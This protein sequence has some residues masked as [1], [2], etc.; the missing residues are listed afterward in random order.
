MTARLAPRSSVAHSSVDLHSHRH[1][2]LDT[3]VGRLV[4]TEENGT[5][6][7]IDWMDERWS[8]SHVKEKPTPMVACALRLLARY[9]AGEPVVFDLPLAPAGTPFQHRVWT[10]MRAIPHGETVTYGEFARSLGSTPRAVGGACGANPI[11]IVIPCHRV[12]AANGPGGYSGGGG[13]ATKARL[14]AIEKGQAPLP[15]RSAPL[16]HR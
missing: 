4:L 9:F 3:P 8:E 1:A 6:V 10:A 16:H 15:F 12:V 2:A 14:L 11:P 7:A 13:L 5:L